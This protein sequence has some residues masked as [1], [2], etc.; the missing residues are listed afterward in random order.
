V[1][2]ANS[3]ARTATVAPPRRRAPPA[4]RAARTPS[5]RDVPPSALGVR[6]DPPGGDIRD[7]VRASRL[8]TAI[9]TPYLPDG[10]IDLA[11]YDAHVAAQIAAGVDGVVVGGTTGEG[12]LMSWDEHVMLI[13]HTVNVFG[14]SLVV[15]GNTGSNST[16]EALH[17][18]EQGFAV[19]MHCALTINPYYG[20]TS[21]AGAERHLE[22]CLDVGPA[23]VY[24]VPGRTGQDLGAASSLRLAQHPNFV[25]MKECAGNG[26]IA[27]LS[28]AGVTCWSGNDD[29]FH[30]GMWHGSGGAGV[31][32]VTSNLVPGL[33]RRLCD[34]RDDALAQD[35][36]PMTGWLFHEPNPI[37]VNT[38]MAMCG[39]SSGVFRAPYVPC[40]A[41][42]RARGAELL[43]PWVEGGHVP[44]A[45]AVRAMRDDEFT[46]LNVW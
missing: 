36:L 27:E 15:V 30:A 31:I 12:Q 29:E 43:R 21:A 39:L 4:P 19:G 32:S 41:A 33:F 1:P 17:A 8:I 37:P 18:T 6:P 13:A 35:L 46:V 2:P 11:S 38:A 16:R 26:R 28:A 24:N 22:A 5:S 23:I 40:T 45:D 14:S 7:A 34:G 42:E 25:G 20:R 10:R 3:P 44:G 9:K